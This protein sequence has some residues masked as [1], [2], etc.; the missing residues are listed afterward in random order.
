ML[1][2]IILILLLFTFYAANAGMEDDILA[3][4]NK[5]RAKKGLVALHEENDMDAAAHKHSKNMATGRVA[6]GHSGFDNR[7]NTFLKNMTGATA[8]AENVAYGAETA[9]EVVA[10]WLK[11][12]GH[13]KNIEGNYNYTGIGIA[14]ARNGQLYYTQIFIKAK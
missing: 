11:S 5:Y 1:K 14:R 4:I 9:E 8:G 10:M 7:L 13:R 3:L 6:F 2:A 12:P